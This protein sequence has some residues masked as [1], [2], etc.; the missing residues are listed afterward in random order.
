MQN[1]INIV[2]LPS[3]FLILIITNIQLIEASPKEASIIKIAILDTGF[4]PNNLSPHP[5]I[6]ILKPHFSMRE[7][8]IEC[9][10]PN[11]SQRRLH[12]HKV[13]DVFINNYKGTQLIEILPIVVFDQNGVSLIKYW[14]DAMPKLIELKINEALSATGVPLQVKSRV[15]LPKTIHFTLA[16]GRIEP[17]IKNM[18]ALFPQDYLPKKQVTIVGSQI[19]FA[20]SSLK[21]PKTYNPKNVDVWIDEAPDENFKGSSRAV[22]IYLATKLSQAT[23]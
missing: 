9:D 23:N 14:Q 18:V 20:E 10:K 8:A 15:S 22:A 2:R 7:F 1:L 19:K 12:G 3:I 11:Y 5:K 6:K 16:S 21:D 17:N 4:C 13:L